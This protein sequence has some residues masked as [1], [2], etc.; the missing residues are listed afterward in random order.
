VGGKTSNLRAGL[1]FDN[2][3]ANDV[4]RDVN[5]GFTAVSGLAP[6]RRT[7]Q[8]G[9]Y[10]MGDSELWV[11]PTRPGRKLTVF[12]N[13]VQADANVA[14]L[15]QIAETGFFLTAPFT[16]RPQ[17][18]I[19]FAIGRVMTNPGITAS[20]RAARA[21]GVRSIGVRRFEYPM[22]FY[23]SAKVLPSIILQPNIQYIVNPGGVS[24]NRNEVV[25]GLKSVI[26][27]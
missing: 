9:W 1:F 8:F 7:N 22:E 27:F 25:A 5:G 24:E 15:R 6:L 11:D 16:A 20:D 4:A 19:G 17:D 10:L 18:D 23:Y 26:I 21:A 2:V 12:A 13:L 3:G 14:R